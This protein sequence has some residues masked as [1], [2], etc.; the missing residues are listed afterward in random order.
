MRPLEQLAAQAIVG[1]ERSALNLPQLPGAIGETL[2]ALDQSD[3]ALTVLRAAGILSFAA[4]AGQQPA[5][6]S[7]QAPDACP[8]DASP[9]GQDESLAELLEAVFNQNALRLQ[10]E[11]LRRLAGGCVPH[12]LLPKL[13][14]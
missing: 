4:L 2:Q 8:L 5:R 11:V 14:D 1:T 7:F 9:H 12:R 3:P 10:A 13:L 6:A